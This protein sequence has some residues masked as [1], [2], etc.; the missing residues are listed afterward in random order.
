MGR[1]RLGTLLQCG[2]LLR[3]LRTNMTAT[4]QQPICSFQLSPSFPA[5]YPKLFSNTNK[6]LAYFR[7]ADD[8]FTAFKNEDD[9]NNF[10]IHLNLLHPFLTSV[11]NH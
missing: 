3:L 10:F 4:I 6:P 5:V 8:T 1:G 9:C 7:Y 11:S 2:P